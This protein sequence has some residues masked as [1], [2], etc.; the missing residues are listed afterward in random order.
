L[1]QT[2]ADQAVIAIENVLPLQRDEGIP[3]AGRR[4]TAEILKVIASFTVRRVK[5]C[6]FDAIVK[7]LLRGLF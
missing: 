1:L 2:F 4:A 7:E 3:R 5:A 6:C